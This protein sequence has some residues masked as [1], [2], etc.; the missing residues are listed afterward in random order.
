[1]A[2]VVDFFTLADAME[3]A[4]VIVQGTSVRYVNPAAVRM[5]G[6]TREELLAMRFW[7]FMHPDDRDLVRERGLARQAGGDVPRHGEYRLRRKDGATVW[8]DFSGAL[9][10]HEGAPAV[11]GTAV[12]VTPSKEAELALR[13]SEA[14]LRRLVDSNILGVIVGD[15]EGR[16][17]EANEA[18]LSM[19]GYTAADLPLRWDVLTPREWRWTDERAI[20]S[21][22]ETG[23]APPYEKEYVHRRGHR[24]PV[25][26]GIA[27]LDPSTAD[28]ICFVLN[29]TE[30][31]RAEEAVESSVAELKASEEKLRRFA[32]REVA[33]REAERKRLGFDLHDNVCQELIGTGMV[34][35]SVA[36]RLGGDRADL[37]AEL[38][39][40]GRFLDEV[41][42]HL[43]GLAR[44]LRPL[45]LRDA[46][47]EQSLR[48]LAERMTSPATSIVATVAG[49]VPRLAE[50]VEV[51]VYRV[52]QEALTNA[53]RHG[54]PRSVEV[55]LAAVNGRVRLEVRDDGRGFDMRARPS[56][57]L[58]LT[59]MEERAA[60]L[61]GSLRVESTPGAGTTVRFECPAVPLVMP[62][63]G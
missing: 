52:A 61:G 51:A 43:R 40:A 8:I 58:G 3:V 46:G 15:F 33:G 60:A 56:D 2:P 44:E 22:H 5:T 16:I 17:T 38:G 10:E 25:L 26:I 36:R 6:Y 41:V 7:D 4:I 13:R 47:L 29:L 48:V 62:T 28:T 49:A 30:R 18:F 21:L 9:I 14:R 50:D 19:L 35:A 57:A 54:E 45:Q 34:I 37:T 55:T 27:L 24:V 11:I 53:L 63:S 32:A 31:K 59:S 42:E 1:M 20:R 39:R 23:I 12:D